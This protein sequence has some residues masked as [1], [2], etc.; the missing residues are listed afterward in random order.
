MPLSFTQSKEMCVPWKEQGQLGV[1]DVK[2]STLGHHFQWRGEG[3]ALC[4]C[5]RSSF[6]LNSTEHCDRRKEGAKL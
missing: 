2:D 1:Q 5:G 6:P 3:S 4:E